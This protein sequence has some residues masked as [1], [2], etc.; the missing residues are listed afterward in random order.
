MVRPAERSLVLLRKHGYLCDMVERRTP[1]TFK[2]PTGAWERMTRL[3][4]W[5]GFADILALPPV[6]PWRYAE[7]GIVRLL[8]VQA[9]SGSSVSEHVEK[10]CEIEALVKYLRSGHRCEIWGWRKLKSTGRTKWFPRIL[11]ASLGPGGAVEFEVT[12]RVEPGI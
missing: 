6:P 8:A 11:V 9:T 3:H 7:H 2:G 1:H 5:L 12:K 4:D 10:L